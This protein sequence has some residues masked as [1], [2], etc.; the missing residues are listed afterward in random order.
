MLHA[1]NAHANLMSDALEA[2]FKA[3]ASYPEAHA[4]MTD[5]VEA[6][7]NKT[8]ARAMVAD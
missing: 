1:S 7:V 5:A 8:L 3:A 2:A 4:A 6:V